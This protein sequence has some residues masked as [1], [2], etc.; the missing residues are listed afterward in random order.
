MKVKAIIFDLGGVYFTDG[1][2]LAARKM[3]K[4]FGLDKD[5]VSQ[6]LTAKSDAGRRYRRG[7]ITFH[8]FWDHVKKQLGIESDNNELNTL[9]LETY[10]PIA[11]TVEIIKRLRSKGIR[12]YYLSDNVKERAVHLQNKHN[13][14]EHFI[15]GIFSH[16]VRLSKIDGLAIFQKALDQT[17]D[18]SSEVVYVDDKKE[19]VDE[20]SKLG[21]KGIHFRSPA[22]L[23]KD[24]GKLGISI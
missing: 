18:D 19:Y 1:S 12:L 7:E 3:A 23:K 10:K 4:R 6:T 20:A 17:G 13:F 9:W 8:K 2:E 11:G 16:K 15:D 21:M 14:L 5:L 24:L 22:Q